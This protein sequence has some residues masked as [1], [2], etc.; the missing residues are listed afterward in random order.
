MAHESVEERNGR[1]AR[2]AG[3]DDWQGWCLS[4]TH[5]RGRQIC[6]AYAKTT[7]EPCQRKPVP[8]HPR[9]PL[10]GGHAPN[11]P[12]NGSFKHGRY[13]TYVPRDLAHDYAQAIQDPELVSLRR[14]IAIMEAREAELLRAVQES[15]GGA[16]AWKLVARYSDHLAHACVDGDMEQILRISQDLEELVELEQGR[17][18]SWNEL[19]RVQEHGRKMKVAESQI[20]KDREMS[21]DKGRALALILWVVQL[22]KDSGAHEEVLREVGKQVRTRLL[23]APNKEIVVLPGQDQPTFQEAP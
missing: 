2:A 4:L 15:I 1:L 12:N 11:G 19:E 7:Q 17:R 21:L 14:Q 6:G 9:C 16:E 20:R 10:H 5:K 18:S 8:G 23:L 3:F 22:L 13:S